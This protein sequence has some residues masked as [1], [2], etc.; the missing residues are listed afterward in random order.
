MTAPDPRSSLDARIPATRN[1]NWR[2][3]AGFG[4]LLVVLWLAGPGVT[5]L[6]RYDRAAVLGGQAWRLVTAHLVHA[7]A[8]HLAWNLAGAGL[9]WWLF[10]AEFSRRGWCL[11]MLASTA[12]IDLGFM[13]FMPQLEWYVGFSG[14]L[15]GCMAAGLVSWLER[16]RDPLTLTVAVLFASKLGWEHFAGPMPFTSATLALP[17]VVE[18]HSLGAIGGA[19]AALGL[20]HARRRRG[21]PL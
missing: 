12:A 19:V 6:L 11:V 2:T 10:A 4:L 21:A 14:V 9:V 8:A 15:H 1:A 18:A 5:A 17:V 7:D 16:A 13:F 20:L 3:A